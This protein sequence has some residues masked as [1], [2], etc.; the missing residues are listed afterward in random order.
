[1]NK[2]PARIRNH[3]RGRGSSS[4]RECQVLAG[5]GL[6]TRLRVDATASSRPTSLES[7]MNSRPFRS[8]LGL[9][10]LLLFLRVG[11]PGATS[12]AADAPPSLAIVAG[13]GSLP[14]QIQLGFDKPPGFQLFIEESSDLSLWSY[15]SRFWTGDGTRETLTLPRE[16]PARFFRLSR[17]PNPAQE[18]VTATANTSHAAYRLF[19][20]HEIG[21]PVSFH[22]HLPA[23]YASE[24]TRRFPV[25]YWLHGSGAGV[26]GVAPISQLYANAMN[27]GQ[28]P[29]V[30]IIFANGLPNGMWCD[31]KNGVTPMESILIHDL[32]PHVDASFRTIATREG[33][34]IEG[35]SMGGYGAG[36]LGLKFAG[37]CRGFSMMGA[38]P[39]QSDFLNDENALVPLSARQT[40]FAEVYGNDADYFEAQSP[41]RQAE[42]SAA[43]LPQ[44]FSIRMIVGAT[45]PMLTNNRALSA[46]FDILGIP[47][48]Y[49]E[50][51]GIGHDPMQVLQ[52]IGPANWLFY[53]TV[54]G[55]GP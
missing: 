25:I 40:I 7:K 4:K 46:H 22:I 31:S 48:F 9:L 32:I 35:F 27:L 19:F 54:F 29:P 38:G 11:L 42:L 49:R 52:G 5:P 3:P 18:W 37:L 10:L 8:R 12:L 33:R 21:R 39:L 13:G 6:V 28:M 30:I 34:L 43:S 14:D 55:T 45:D 1:M 44:G 24:P 23:A 47:H 26:S 36:R 20:S 53:R 15:R 17:Y 2:K 50:L 51:P 41:R 16:S